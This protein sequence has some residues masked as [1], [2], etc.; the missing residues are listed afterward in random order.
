MSEKMLM[1]I[2]VNM[3]LLKQKWFL[4]WFTTVTSYLKVYSSLTGAVLKS[5]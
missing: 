2:F 5:K 4:T 3:K 1:K